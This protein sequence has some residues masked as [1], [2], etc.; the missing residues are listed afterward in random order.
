MSGRRS[1]VCTVRLMVNRVTTTNR[2]GGKGSVRVPP[3]PPPPG[4]DDPGSFRIR[5][6]G[7]ELVIAIWMRAAARVPPRGDPA[8]AGPVLVVVRYKVPSGCGLPLG[9][10]LGGIL[11]WPALSWLL[12][13]IKGLAPSRQHASAAASGPT[14]T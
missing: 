3:G 13:L 14:S 5:L 7:E 2:R 1:Y 11:Q 6:S 9:S 8:V 10:P 12:L 4:S